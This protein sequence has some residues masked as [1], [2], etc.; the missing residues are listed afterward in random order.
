MTYA[1]R[2]AAVVVYAAAIVCAGA[3]ARRN[4]A[5]TDLYS[6]HWLAD[7]QISPDGAQVAY[8]YVRSTPSTTATKP[9]SGPCRPPAVLRASSLLARTI[10]RHGGRPMAGV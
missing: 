4:I 9:R 2:R 5:D 6:F 10:F 3:T 1:R 8:T 7:P